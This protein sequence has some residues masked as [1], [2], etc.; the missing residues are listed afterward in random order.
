[1]KNEKSKT[2]KVKNLKVGDGIFEDFEGKMRDRE[3]EL[4]EE[5]KNPDFFLS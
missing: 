2:K 4:K 5:T 1:M 3:L